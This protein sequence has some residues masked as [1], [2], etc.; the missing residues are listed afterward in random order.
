MQKKLNSNSVK[1]IFEYRFNAIG[2]Y[3]K[4]NRFVLTS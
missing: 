1:T 2:I 4:M 3:V